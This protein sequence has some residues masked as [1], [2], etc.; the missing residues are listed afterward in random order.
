M[1]RSL[2][3]DSWEERIDWDK[4][5]EERSWEERSDHQSW[6]E[7][8]GGKSYRPTNRMVNKEQLEHYLQK[9]PCSEE[10]FLNL[11]I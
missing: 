5:W 8:L 3:H 7:R 9:R 11:T 4:S 1:E 10:F 2:D 6:K